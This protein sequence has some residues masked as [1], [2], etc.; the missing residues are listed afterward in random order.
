MNRLLITGG[1]GFLGYHTTQA[2]LREDSE[3]KIIIADLKAPTWLDSDDPDSQMSFSFCDM[4]ALEDVMG[5]VS[6]LGI[7]HVIHLA[8]IL[9]TAEQV[10][11]PVPSFEL[12]TLATIQFLDQ[13]RKSYPD[14]PITL[15]VNGNGSWNNTYAI[16]KEAAGRVALM[17]NN[18]FHTRYSVVRPF[19]AYGE[20]QKAHPIRKIGPHM[21]TRALLNQ[22]IEIFGNGEQEF[23]LVYAGDVGEALYLATV[24]V[25]GR[26]YS[27]ILEAGSGEVITPV[28]FAEKV[29]AITGSSSRLKHLPMRPGEPEDTYLVAE[30]ESLRQIGMDYEEMR[31]FDSIK[32]EETIDWY[33]ARIAEGIE[34]YIDRQNS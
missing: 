7:T 27:E 9:G 6:S 1:S 17:F 30:P 5:L 14:I 34:I 25:E 12:N 28:L 18:E 24:D 23:D 8:G 29:I 26:D 19:N 31:G 22:D 4:R 3:A 11:D 20:Y 16:S 15:T 32:L 10:K 33:A 21:I 13:M 2:I